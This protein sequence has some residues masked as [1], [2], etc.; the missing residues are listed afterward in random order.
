MKATPQIFLS[1]AREDEEKVKKLYQKLSDAGFKPWMD[2]K[3]IL[4]GE[5]WESSIRRA[6]RRSDFFLACLSA[7][8]VQK[9]GVIQKEIRYALDIWQEKLEDDIYLI[10]VRLEVCEV[11]ERLCDFQW[12]NLFEKGG[13]SRL[14]K[15]IQV[16]MERRADVSAGAES[17]SD[18]ATATPSGEVPPEK[19][20]MMPVAFLKAKLKGRNILYRIIEPVTVIGRAGD[21]HLEIPDE[22]DNVERY[23]A[24]VFCKDGIFTIADGYEN[25]STKFGTFVNGVKVK[26]QTRL[27][28]RPGDRIVLGGFRK[29]EA[30]EL[31]RGACEIIFEEGHNV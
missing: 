10:P 27:P 9:R 21:C 13:W 7:N 20:R 29:K 1:Y 4:P 19:Q 24:T 30:H 6:V 5:R 16:G 25:R 12:V 31:S 22:C 14:V 28:L 3:D 11:P 18:A 8:S 26:P 2:K 17:S 23:H 15:A